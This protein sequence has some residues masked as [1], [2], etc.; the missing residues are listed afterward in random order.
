MVEVGALRFHAELQWMPLQ[1]IAG[2][3][4]AIPDHH[5]TS[6]LK[7]HR[8]SKELEYVKVDRDDVTK[9]ALELQQNH[10]LNFLD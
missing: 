1:K 5:L 8:T 3:S 4:S 9:L 10:L 6:N 7:S 2:T